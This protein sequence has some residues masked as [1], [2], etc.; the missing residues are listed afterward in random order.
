MAGTT[1]AAGDSEGIDLN[2][3]EAFLDDL[4]ERCAAR[5]RRR[6]G[7]ILR[8]VS[9][10]RVGRERWRACVSQEGIPRLRFVREGRTRIRAIENSERAL[11]DLLRMLRSRGLPP[12]TGM[13]RDR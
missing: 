13:Q 2:A 1:D 10:S 4:D 8:L 6:M 7:E 12:P 11:D 9:W 3:L 5:H